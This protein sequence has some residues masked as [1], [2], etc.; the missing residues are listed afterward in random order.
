MSNQKPVSKPP[1]GRNSEN[2]RRPSWKSIRRFSPANSSDRGSGTELQSDRSHH[3]IKKGSISGPVLTSTTNIKIA[4]TEGVNATP[5]RLG[6]ISGS[7]DSKDRKENDSG[8][9]DGEDQISPGR[10][11][12]AR[13]RN[14]FSGS[15]LLGDYLN[16]QSKQRDSGAVELSG[17]GT[18]TPT[19]EKG[20]KRR[21]SHLFSIGKEKINNLADSCGIRHASLSLRREN[22]N[23]PKRKSWSSAVKT[24]ESNPFG[25]S[26]RELLSQSLPR[27]RSLLQHSFDDLSL[28]KSFADAVDKL[29][30]LDS[31]EDFKTAP[32]SGAITANGVPPFPRGCK[33][34]NTSSDAN[35]QSKLPM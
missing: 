21:S 30:F 23:H 16:G 13:F 15:F 5:L 12:L 18:V 27:R 29:D 11:K 8:R 25:D 7:P 35:D 24:S 9:P 26:M 6:E 3:S 31:R 1:N 19:F 14:T 10:Q 17:S 32:A 4:A 22:V 34:S 33:F 28:E 2:G 20:S